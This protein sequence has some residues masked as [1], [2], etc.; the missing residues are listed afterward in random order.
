MA[1]LPLERKRSHGG[2]NR[3][4]RDGEEPAKEGDVWVRGRIEP[5]V[6]QLLSDAPL[7]HSLP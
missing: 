3:R 5:V 2:A 4:T 7:S 6:G 1:S